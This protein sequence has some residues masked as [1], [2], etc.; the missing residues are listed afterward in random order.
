MRIARSVGIFLGFVCLGRGQES[1][2]YTTYTN[3][4][5]VLAQRDAKYPPIVRVSDPGTK[6]H[7]IFTGFFFYQVLQFD[8]T[9]RYLLGL[10][11]Y[12]QSRDVKADD[13]GDV[14]Y[15]DL[16]DGFKW[17]KIGESTAWNWQQGNR[18][19][20]RPKSDE[21]VW[22]DRSDDGKK[23]VCRLYNFRNGKT[24]VLPRP[25]YDLSPDGSMALTHDFERMK[26]A[27]TDYVGIE[28]VYKNQY[29]PSQT[30][31]WKMNMDNGRSELI[32]SLQKMAEIA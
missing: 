13:R 24:R 25:I 26:H 9:G 22:N 10:R 11:V 31:I 15:I 6:N 20:W 17:T 18:L 8:T 23:F 30:G 14:G 19:Q 16:K 12:F 4:E 3:F 27:G 5:Q 29:A 1:L 7:P 28:D 21:I 2:S 32:M